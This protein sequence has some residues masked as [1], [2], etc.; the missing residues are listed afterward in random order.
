MGMGWDGEEEGGEEGEE[1]EE[2]EEEED[3]APYSRSVD[4]FVS[5]SPSRTHTQ[6]KS[7]D[8]R[9]SKSGR[10][11]TFTADRSISPSLQV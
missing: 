10:S 7:E 9:S 3:V 2:E 11:L 1:E 8:A 4:P 5:T 6:G